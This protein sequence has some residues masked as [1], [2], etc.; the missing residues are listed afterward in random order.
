MQHE[1]QWAR[2]F[3]NSETQPVRYVQ[4]Y[5][6]LFPIPEGVIKFFIIVN[7]TFFF[8]NEAQNTEKATYW[9]IQGKGV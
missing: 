5:C 2:L 3:L 8:S 1:R 9:V 6:F 7:L 4:Q